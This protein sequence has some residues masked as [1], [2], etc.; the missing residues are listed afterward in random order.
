MAL[1]VART[2]LP[3]HIDG[4]RQADLLLNTK[5]VQNQLPTQNIVKTYA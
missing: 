5:V 2:F 1:Y 3:P 4:Q